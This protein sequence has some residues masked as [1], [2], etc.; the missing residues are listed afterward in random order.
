MRVPTR[1]TECASVTS[2]FDDLFAVGQ[3]P[4]LDVLA[5]ASAALVRVHPDHDPIR[6][7]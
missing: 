7:C 4:D 3:E 1:A 6:F 2:V 5:D